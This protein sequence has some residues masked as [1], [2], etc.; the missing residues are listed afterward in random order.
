M[1]LGSSVEL[2]ASKE[3]ALFSLTG[4]P[5][6]CPKNDVILMRVLLRDLVIMLFEGMVLKEQF[7]KQPIKIITQL[8]FSA[9]LLFAQCF[10]F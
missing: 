7:S 1:E 6:A 8:Y 4:L 3:D 5:G 10:P 9:M 2:R